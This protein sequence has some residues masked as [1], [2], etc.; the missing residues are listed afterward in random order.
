ARPAYAAVKRSHWA[1]DVVTTKH[2][3]HTKVEANPILG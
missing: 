3:N 2:T 1:V